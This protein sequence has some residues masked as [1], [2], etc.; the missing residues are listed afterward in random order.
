MRLAMNRSC[1]REGRRQRRMPCRDWYPNW[2]HRNRS[3]QYHRW[4]TW[5]YCLYCYQNPAA[6]EHATRSIVGS[7]RRVSTPATTF[8]TCAHS[9]LCGA[10]RCC[11]RLT[12]RPCGCPCI[13]VFPVEV[14][15]SRACHADIGIGTGTVVT[16]RSGATVGTRAC[17]VY[18]AIYE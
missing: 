3:Q 14:E 1:H 8:F 6:V 15:L 17:I 7:V 5:L 10:R 18:N 2:D 13:A 16:G 4:H 11:F 9:V 12:N